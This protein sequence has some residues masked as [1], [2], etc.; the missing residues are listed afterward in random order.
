MPSFLHSRRRLGGN[1]GTSH[2]ARP[3][4]RRGGHRVHA[5]ETSRQCFKRIIRAA[6]AA[7]A[8]RCP[9]H[10]DHLRASHEV[11]GLERRRREARGRRPRHRRP[12]ARR[13]RRPGAPRRS[14]RAR[15]RRGCPRRRRGRRPWRGRR[16]AVDR[17]ERRGRA[18]ERE[19]RPRER[20]RLRPAKAL[21]GHGGVSRYET[22]IAR[23]SSLRFS[24]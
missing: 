18:R 12:R 10:F 11:A 16:R 3:V 4:E 2:T 15:R 9:G 14:P 20:L 5:A 23:I 21:L 24:E 6:A 1:V 19:A 13:G 8:V 22:T 7:H 17:E